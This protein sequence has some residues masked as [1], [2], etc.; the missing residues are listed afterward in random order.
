MKI[1]EDVMKVIEHIR[2]NKNF[3]MKLQENDSVLTCKNNLKKEEGEGEKKGDDASDSNDECV[4]TLYYTRTVPHTM[5]HINV[6][7]NI[8]KNFQ[9]A[10]TLEHTMDLK[11]GNRIISFVNK[12]DVVFIIPNKKST[13]EAMRHNMSLEEKQVI[14]FEGKEGYKSVD[15]PCEIRLLFSKTRPNNNPHLI[16]ADGNHVVEFNKKNFPSPEFKIVA[17]FA[18]FL[19]NQAPI[20]D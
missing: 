19:N 14:D 12:Y 20:F 15:P 16:K 6:Y 13:I 8:S 5:P 4:E 2:S 11:L 1:E 18:N 17:G 3:Y 9:L 10:A 7:R